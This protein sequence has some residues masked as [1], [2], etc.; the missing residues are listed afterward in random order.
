[1]PFRKTKI[2]FTIILFTMV[3]SLVGCSEGYSSVM[4]REVH[5]ENSWQM[6]YA[7]FSGT[8]DTTINMKKGD[9]LELYIN[10]TTKEG[11]L[12]VSALNK[13][14]EVLYK[15]DTPKGEIKQPLIVTE[16]TTYTVQVK[17]KHK[18][19]FKIGWDI[20]HTQ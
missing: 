11:N 18:G 17:G 10:V 3:L 8:K 16:D 6:S 5:T 4:S 7:S 19:G 2:F 20:I 9:I 14:G 1:M 12:E 15:V 13:K